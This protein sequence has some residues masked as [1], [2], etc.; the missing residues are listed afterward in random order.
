MMISTGKALFS[1]IQFAVIVKFYD[2][3][4]YNCNCESS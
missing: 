2:I 4:L 3:V 1:I